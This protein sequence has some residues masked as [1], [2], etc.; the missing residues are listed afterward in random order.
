MCAILLQRMAQFVGC[1]VKCD[2]IDL[3]SV[4][5]AVSVECVEGLFKVSI[6]LG[7]GL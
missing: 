4:L 5:S 1:D 2:E 6:T 7:D 3:R